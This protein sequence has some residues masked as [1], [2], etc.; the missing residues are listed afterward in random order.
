MN[1]LLSCAGRRGYLVR[2]FKEALAGRGKVVATNSI[3]NTPAMLAADEAVVMPPIEDPSYAARVIDVCEKREVVLL[4]SLFD[5]DLAALA[6][7][8]DR[9][10]EVGTTAVV[11]TPEVVDICFDKWKTYRF[12]LALGLG[13]PK[14]YL[15]VEA[16]LA[17]VAREELSFPLIVKP[18]WGTGSIGVVGAYD[19]DHLRAAAHHVRRV[20]D[21]THLS[22]VHSEG[23]D[24]RI[25]IQQ[26]LRGVEYGVDLVNDLNGEFSCCFVKQKLGMRSGETDSAVTVGDDEISEKAE[27]ISARL[28]HVGLLDIDI[29]RQEGQV[30]LLEMNPRFGGHYPF[31]HLAGAN[32]PA[33]L[34][35]WSQGLEANP[36]WLRVRHG[37]QGFKEIVPSLVHPIE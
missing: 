29:I 34:I 15:T 6:P 37:V 33:A 27:L 7:S 18:R 4:C 32:I 14:T 23:R 28:R 21:H 20:V 25:I 10:E 1:V 17:E 24:E 22:A 35:A 8:R 26:M 5:L 12:G 31:S 19:A 16:A 30:F 9:L 36:E 2:Y 13:V 3:A 11:S